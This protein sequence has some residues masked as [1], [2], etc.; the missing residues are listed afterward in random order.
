MSSV[1]ASTSGGTGALTSVKGTACKIC[2]EY[3]RFLLGT[4]INLGAFPIWYGPFVCPHE[5]PLPRLPPSFFLG[6]VQLFAPD[7]NGGDAQ[8]SIELLYGV[9]ES[10]VVGR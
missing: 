1:F 7:A 3:S 6:P 8:V 2:A 4:L 10:L 5:S 9:K